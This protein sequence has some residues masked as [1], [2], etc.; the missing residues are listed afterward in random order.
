MRCIEKSL[1]ERTNLYQSMKETIS[2]LT[3]SG[4][5]TALTDGKALKEFSKLLR[6]SGIDPEVGSSQKIYFQSL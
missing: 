4:E 2:S 5:N 6:N 3:I 1:T